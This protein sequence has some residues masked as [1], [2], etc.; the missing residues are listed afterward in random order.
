MQNFQVD[1]EV[2]NELYDKFSEMP[3]LFVVHETP[4]C[5]I[6]EE[7]KIC[8]E[9]TGGKTVKGTKK[10]LG[11]LKAE[12]I[13]LCTPLIEWYLQHGL[14]LTAVH[15]LIEHKPGMSFSWFP[16]EVA[17]AWR[18]ADKDP[19]KKQ[20]GD[21]AKRKGNSFYRKMT[22]DL[23]RHKRIR[24][25][26]EERAVVKSLRSLFFDNLEEIGGAYEIKESKR[27]VMIKRPYQ[28]GIAVNQLAK[29]R[30]LEFYYDFLDKYFSRKY[31]ELCYM[32]M[33]SFY[34]VISGDSLDDIIKPEMKQAYEADKKNWLATDKFRERTPG[35][36]KPEFVVTRGV[37]L[38]TKC[39]LFK[40]R[41]SMK[42]NIAAKVF[43]RS[44]M[45]CTF[46]AIKIPWM[47][48]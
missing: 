30:M 24:F 46:S 15:Q 3:P 36:F 29:L 20:L 18:E 5:S 35:S 28:S 1:I 11:F 10:L 14:R 48:F 7:I 13:P 43:Q 45:M 16:E 32:D 39:T 8:K 44:I 21:V 41:D 27:T 37:W 9:K 31:F 42:I 17:N 34:L 23:G 6:P 22:E 47:F 38:I 40:M 25:T 26:R 19:L 12:K 33:D 4:D 2:P